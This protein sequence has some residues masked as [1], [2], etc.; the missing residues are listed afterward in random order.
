VLSE[1]VEM[2]RQFKDFSLFTELNGVIQKLEDKIH[3]GSG[4][5]TPIIHIEKNEH[6]K[7]LEHLDTLYQAILKQI[8]LKLTYRSF[9]ARSASTFLFHG[10]ILK[11]YNNRWF[12]VGRKHKAEP[13]FVFALD[14][15]EKVEIDLST[16]YRNA[17]FSADKYYK[18]TIGITVNNRIIK[19]E[20]RVDSRN[21]PYIK[22]KPFHHSQ[23][24]V[25]EREDRS[26]V[27]RMQVCHNFEL[28][29]LLLG[30]GES[31]EVLKPL[32]LRRIIKEKLEKGLNNYEI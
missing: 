17:D 27:F 4:G 1:S 9:K 6:L 14:R 29:R 19:V 8:V 20:F 13:I 3:R 18:D 2:L 23:E 32:Y 12:V 10:Y 30:F 31:L 25:E 15:I 7:G 24:V 22:T 26:V 16:V 28:E 5:Q 21:A 11:E